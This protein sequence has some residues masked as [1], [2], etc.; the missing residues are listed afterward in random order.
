MWTHIYQRNETCKE[1]ENMENQDKSFRLGKRATDDCIEEQ[2]KKDDAPRQKGPMP[3]F[4][5]VA[6]DSLHNYPLE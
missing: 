1:A 6:R 2:C 3:S 5:S 4:I